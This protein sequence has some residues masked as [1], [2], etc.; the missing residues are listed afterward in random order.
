MNK[1][2]IRK[3]TFL[4]A[5]AAVLFIANAF[6]E[7]STITVTYPTPHAKYKNVQVERFLYIC[8]SPSQ[9]STVWYFV[10]DPVAVSPVTTVNG[11]FLIKRTS[12]ADGTAT[13]TNCLFRA[14]GPDYANNG[15]GTG[16]YGFDGL[17]V[18][19]NA[20]LSAGGGQVLIG[21]SPAKLNHRLKAETVTGG[22]RF[23]VVQNPPSA[24]NRLYGEMRG[25]T[26][27][28]QP[29]TPDT[30][31]QKKAQFRAR[32]DQNT[33]SE[34][35]DLFGAMRIDAHYLRFGEKANDRFLY[36]A[37]GQMDT[38]LIGAQNVAPG[39]TASNVFLQVGN[40]G[41]GSSA[42]GDWRTFSSRE[43]KKDIAPLSPAQYADSLSMIADTLLWHYRFKG[44]AA[45]SRLRMGLITEETPKAL[46]APEGKS[47]NLYDTLGHLAAAMKQLKKE[48]DAL[49]MRL[50]SLEQKR[51]KLMAAA[52]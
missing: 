52:K 37:Q 1:A 39:Y 40:P 17:R 5:A 11:D 43:F 35:D 27:L 20:A 7:N 19:A 23:L 28:S 29:S 51:A 13:F 38:V 42:A 12:A 21:S 48:N 22:R 16:P 34:S 10:A 50:E 32:F 49:K 2:R 36:T 25:F 14:G 24:V 15:T 30:R 26:D 18:R 45:D 4:V 33:A 46:I 31:L 8:K 44:D 41:D 9:P 6:C 3:T 47:L